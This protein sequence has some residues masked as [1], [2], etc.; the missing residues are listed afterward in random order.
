MFEGDAS[1]SVRLN[2]GRADHRGWGVF[3][4]A[5]LADEDTNPVQWSIAG[6]VG[7][8][9]L[10]ASRPN[11]SF[12]IGYFIIDVKDGVVANLIGLK[13]TEQGVE[14]YYEAELT[15]WFHVTPDLQIVDPGLS[16]SETVVI[17]GLRGNISF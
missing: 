2:D 7:G 9:G 17:L 10:M 13:S 5:G 12:G 14:I 16:A 6:G 4:M 15:P 11:D 1:K 8:R 3:L